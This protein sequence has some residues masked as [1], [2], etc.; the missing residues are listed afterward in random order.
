MENQVSPIG[1]EIDLNKTTGTK[2]NKDTMD[3]Y[4][5]ATIDVARQYLFEK[6]ANKRWVPGEDMVPYSG[7]YFDEKEILAAIDVLLNGWLVMGDKSA[8]LERKLPEQFGK[9]YGVLTNSGSSANLLMMSALKLKEEFV[10]A[11]VGGFPTTINPIFQ[12]GNRICPVDIDDSFN[13]DLDQVEELLS[14]LRKLDPTYLPKV[15]TFAHALG[16][17]P[18][19]NRVMKIVEEY[20]MILLEDCCD[21]MGGTFDG[22]LLG[23]FG[24]MASCSFYPAHHMTMGEGGFVACNTKEMEDRVRSMR[25]W[26]RGCYCVGPKANALK[27]GTCKERFKEWIPDAFPGE[28]F[29]HKYVYTE[30]GYNLKPIEVSG[31][32]G[33]VQLNKLPDIHELRKRNFALMYEI[34]KPYEEFFQLPKA[35]HLCDPSWFAFAVTLRET[36]PF[37]RADIVD[38]LEEHKIQTRPY[39]AGNILLQPAYRNM[40]TM[41]PERLKTEFPKATHAMTN[42]F[43]HG[44]SPVIRIEQIDYI[45][46]VLYKFME[47]YL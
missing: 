40:T 44:T 19:M 3:Y 23:S 37:K 21:A 15:F 33:L 41:S 25:E 6:E 34:Y 10:L 2:P 9:N 26:G 28:I 14:N 32:I 8:R 5:K 17:S 24:T 36:A 38:W 20:D 47:K 1:D 11:P 7:P 18:D 45:K 39:F 35:T 12:T 43:F 27:C 16:N 46:E 30:I 4:H 29:D 42:T 31:A 13:P 22:K